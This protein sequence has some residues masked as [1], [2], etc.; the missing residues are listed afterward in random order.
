MRQSFRAAIYV[1]VAALSS[2][3]APENRAAPPS[4][5]LAGLAG[6]WVGMATMTSNS[7]PQSNFKCIVTYIPRRDAPGMRQTLRCDDGASFKLHAATDLELQ[8]ERLTGAWQ[9]KIN[10][11]G[12]T[13]EGQLTPAG[14]DIQLSGQFF[15]AHMA[16]AGEGCAQS[17]KV[18]PKNSDVF[19]ELAATLKKC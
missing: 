15:A 6:R 8:G 7:G 12:G 13:V 3:A 4:D 9:D 18:L 17:V 19:R 5:P 2:L 1:A 10:D 16:V 14:F 11:I